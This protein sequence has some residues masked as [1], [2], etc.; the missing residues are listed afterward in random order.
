MSKT[1]ISEPTAWSIAR[2][3]A[4]EVGEN[5]AQGETLAVFLIGSRR[6]AATWPGEATSTR[7]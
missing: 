1:T 7:S 3:F 4:T 6:R 2:S 5:I